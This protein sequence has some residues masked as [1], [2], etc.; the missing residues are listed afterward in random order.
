MYLNALAYVMLFSFG[1]TAME[2]KEYEDSVKIPGRYFSFIPYNGIDFKTQIKCSERYLSV[3][4]WT[5]MA[6]RLRVIGS[7]MI[8]SSF[9]NRKLVVDWPIVP[10]EMPGSWSDFFMDGPL[11]DFDQ[12]SLAQE[13]G[14]S[15][16][17]IKNA[18]AQDRII[19]NLGNL[20]SLA[21]CE[22]LKNL[23]HDKKQVI[24]FTTTITFTLARE[25]CSLPVYRSLRQMFYK[26]LVPVNR[27]SETVKKFKEDNEFD[28]KYMIGVHYR[29]WATGR[30][31]DRSSS[32]IKDHNLMYLNR[33][34]D[35][36]KEAVLNPLFRQDEKPVA[37][38]LATDDSRIKDAML[39]DP[40]LKG[41]IVTTSFVVDRTSIE[42]TQ[43]GLI[44]FFILGATNYIIGTFQSSFSDEAAHL[45]TYDHK[46]NIGE[47][48]Y[49]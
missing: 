26:N 28:K 38:F 44:D 27:I 45:T 7:A 1:L 40:D 8:A 13:V 23:T 19:L 10:G 6:N 31:D 16:D 15:L 37:F 3:T 41:L 39:T 5:G 4:I 24:Y 11:M 9:T 33:F 42:G 35:K 12:T 25:V 20:N 18:K 29:S 22:R 49:K 17:D 30:P 48:A 47:A 43:N 32:L 34:I 21:G 14:L 2:A 36:M 46:V